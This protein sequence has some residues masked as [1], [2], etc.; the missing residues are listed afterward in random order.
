M[1]EDMGMTP[2]GECCAVE[3]LWTPIANRLTEAEPAVREAVYQTLT[4]ESFAWVSG[5]GKHQL[6]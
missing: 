4:S 6:S 2:G 5:V 3:V 1:S